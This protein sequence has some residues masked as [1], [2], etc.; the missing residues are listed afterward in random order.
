MRKKLIAIATL[1]S[2]V[3][4]GIA[5]EKS[6]DPVDLKWIGPTPTVNTPSSFGVPFDKGMVTPTSEFNMTTADGQNLPHD[7]WVLAYWPDGSVKWGGFSAVV[8]ADNANV[9]L[10]PKKITKKSKKKKSTLPTGYVTETP[11]Q[12]IVQTGEISAY[13]PRHG[14]NLVDSIVKGGLRNSGAIRLVAET[15]TKAQT[16]E[17]KAITEQRNFVSTLD[18]SLIHI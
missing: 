16:S 17:G 9:T 14:S 15:E 5:A 13:I 10:T 6:A 11:E 7:F 4:S 18:L 2:G 12:Y 1:L 3:V 8:P